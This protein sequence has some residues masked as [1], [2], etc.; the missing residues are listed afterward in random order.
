MSHLRSSFR[1]GVRPCLGT[2]AQKKTGDAGS[3]ASRPLH[4]T[5][6]RLGLHHRGGHCDPPG[7]SAG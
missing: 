3:R 6:L 2:H 7:P 4:E 1:S 5:L